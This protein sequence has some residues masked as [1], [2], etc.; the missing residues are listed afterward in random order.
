M[1]IFRE[2]NWT[3][4]E[5]HVED[6]SDVAHLDVKMYCKINQFPS[7]PFF[8]PHFKPHGPRVFFKHYYFIFDTKLGNSVCEIFCIACA[9]V[10][11]TTKLDKTW[12]SGIPLKTITL[13]T[14]NQFHLL[15][16]HSAIQKLEHH[17]ILI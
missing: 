10:A 16:S 14:C 15:V 4:R 5:Y 8:G 12:L 1:K 3:D 11:C 7:L 9:C 6:N 17:L 13:S 2:R